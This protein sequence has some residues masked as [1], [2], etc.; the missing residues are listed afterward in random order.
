VTQRDIG[1]IRE[2]SAECRVDHK[3][4]QTA[5]PRTEV[6][7]ILSLSYIHVLATMYPSSTPI[8][9]IQLSVS[10]GWHRGSSRVLVDCWNMLVM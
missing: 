7:V 6:V 1:S 9:T 4:T 3:G 2:A 8:N 5:V 10:M